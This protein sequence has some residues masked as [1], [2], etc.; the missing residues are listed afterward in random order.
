MLNLLVAEL[1][2][3]KLILVQGT[4]SILELMEII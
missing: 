3:I 4:G 1:W 2:N